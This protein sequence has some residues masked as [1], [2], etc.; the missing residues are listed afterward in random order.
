MWLLRTR[1]LTDGEMEEV[2]KYGEY[3]NIDEAVSYSLNEK[4]LELNSLFLQ[5]FKLRTTARLAKGAQPTGEPV[6]ASDV[7]G[8]M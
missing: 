1:V 4:S 6:T 5:Q 7:E 8:A 2:E 3:L